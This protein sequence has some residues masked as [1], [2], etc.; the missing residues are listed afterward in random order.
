MAASCMDSEYHQLWLMGL[1]HNILKWGRQQFVVTLDTKE[2]LL[3]FPD[4]GTNLINWCF[5][6]AEAAQVGVWILV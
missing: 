1:Q 5:V 4:E 3:A 2:V 6:R